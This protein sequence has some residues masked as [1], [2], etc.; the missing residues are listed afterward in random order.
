MWRERAELA[1][2]RI[3]EV[4]IYITKINV[5]VK[6]GAGCGLAGLVCAKFGSSS[7]L[8]DHPSNNLVLANC[9]RNV[10]V[11]QLESCCQ[12][13]PLA[14]GRFTKDIQDLPSI[15][16]IIGSD[17]FYDRKGKKFTNLF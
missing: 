15:D 6:L 5:I 13:K 14:W 9:I 11:N 12:V 4:N 3:L 7:I 1:G 10:K 8:T 2:K 16:Y 17:T